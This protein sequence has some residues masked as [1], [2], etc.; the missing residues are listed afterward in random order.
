MS[1]RKMCL[2]ISVH[3]E[4]KRNVGKVKPTTVVFVIFE[5]EK[6]NPAGAKTVVAV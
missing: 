1:H 5:L 4:V 3:W 6:L 2:P